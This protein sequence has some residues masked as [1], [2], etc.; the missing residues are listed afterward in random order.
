M[1]AAKGSS[2]EVARQTALNQ[3]RIEPVFCKLLLAPGPRKKTTAV[4]SQFG[5]DDVGTGK[6]C[7]TEN[8]SRS[9]LG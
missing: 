8:Q 6:V 9:T 4:G 2:P 7:F 1:H 5:I 3:A